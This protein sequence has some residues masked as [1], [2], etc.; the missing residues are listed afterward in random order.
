MDFINAGHRNWANLRKRL[1]S[2]PYG[3]G[4]RGEGGSTGWKRRVCLPFIFTRGLL[5]RFW[6]GGAEPHQRLEASASGALQFIKLEPA[7]TPVKRTLSRIGCPSGSDDQSGG[8]SRAQRRSASESGAVRLWTGPA[9]A[10]TRSRVRGG[11]PLAHF[12]PGGRADQDRPAMR[13]NWR[14]SCGRGN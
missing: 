14:G 9:L 8:G 11:G 2:R 4:A 3:W 6:E 7:N 1:A 12:H 10:S 5:P 13:A